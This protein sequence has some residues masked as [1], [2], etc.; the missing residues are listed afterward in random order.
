MIDFELKPNEKK[1]IEYR[2]LV[3]EKHQAISMADIRFKFNF[4]EISE[5][6]ALT[7]LKET[8]ALN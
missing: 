6:K 3:D 8:K 1:Y 2:V 5:P 4:F 7:A